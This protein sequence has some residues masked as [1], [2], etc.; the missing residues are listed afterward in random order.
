MCLTQLSRCKH[1]TPAIT[2]SLSTEGATSS[3]SSHLITTY[4]SFINPER[5][6][7]WVGLVGRQFTVYPYKWLPISCRSSAGQWK[8]AG[9]RP[10]FYHWATPPT[11]RLLLKLYFY[12]FYH[13]ITK[14]W[15]GICRSYS[16]F[17]SVSLFGAQCK[18]PDQKKKM[19]MSWTDAGNE[20]SSTNTCI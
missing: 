18:K 4:Y 13:M 8:F 20:L 2:R 7:G 5:M 1:T 15:Q 11:Y 6:K 16:D 10:T 12:C 17:I 14:F 3:D 9:Q 19:E